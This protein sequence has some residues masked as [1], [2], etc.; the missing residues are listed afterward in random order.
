MIV[1]VFRSRLNE[2]HRD[3]YMAT[4]GR[5]NELAVTMPG[6]ISHKVFVAADG[7][8]CTIVEFE[9]DAGQNTWAHNAEHVAAKK[10]GRKAYYSEYSLQICNVT[11]ESKFPQ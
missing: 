6:Y 5:M 4:A 11:R 1:T 9:S 10:E 7:E 2:E 3:A 8:R